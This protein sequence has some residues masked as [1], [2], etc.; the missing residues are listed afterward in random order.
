MVGFGDTLIKFLKKKSKIDN[1]SFDAGIFG[2]Y[3]DSDNV[4]AVCSS[5]EKWEIFYNRDRI[6]NHSVS[7]FCNIDPERGISRINETFEDFEIAEERAKA[8]LYS[9]NS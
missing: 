7:N 3:P 9:M 2:I 4:F 1:K 8:F 5:Q 6:G